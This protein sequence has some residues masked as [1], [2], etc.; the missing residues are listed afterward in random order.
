MAKRVVL[1]I[2]GLFLAAAA[3]WV[4]FT[5][6]MRTKYPPV[7]NAIRRMNRAVVNPRAMAT[8]GTAG[9]YASV[10]R[11]RGRTSG[12]RYETPV[13]AVPT[14][15]GFVIPLPYG[16]SADWLK[17]VLAAGSASIAHDGNTFG[18]DHPELLSKTA[19]DPYFAAKDQRTHSLYGVDQFLR[20]RRSEPDLRH[21]PTAT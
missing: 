17:N 19:V 4:G 15:D 11:H 6:A 3:V 10:I 12:T 8:A 13:Q 16:T 1:S 9:A 5:V 14:E 2:G 20:V 7:Q 18:V 21:D